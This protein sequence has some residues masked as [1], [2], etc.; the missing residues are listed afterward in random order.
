MP[1]RPLGHLR[2]LPRGSGGSHRRA[3]LEKAIPKEKLLRVAE[4]KPKKRKLSRRDLL[5]FSAL[6]EFFKNYSLAA[7]KRRGPF[8]APGEASIVQIPDACTMALA[9]D[10]GTGTDEAA[11][12][13]DHMKKSDPDYTIHLGDIYYVGSQESIDENCRGRKQR[14]GYESV[15]WPMGKHGSFALN[16]N[17][18]AYARDGAYFKWIQEDLKQPSSCFVLHNQNWCI[19]GLDTAY[20]SEG[21]PWIGW[22]ADY[23]GWRWFLPSCKIPDA[24]LKWLE[25]EVQPYLTLEKGLILL[26]HHQYFSSF[27]NEYR[28]AAQQLSRINGFAN[29]DLLWFWGHEH[30]LSAYDIY[31]NQGIRAFGRCLGHGGM[32]VERDAPKLTRQDRPLQFYDWRSY[33]PDT[34][35]IIQ[36]NAEKDQSTFGVNG[37][38]TFEFTGASLKV[39]CRDINNEEIASEV[40]GVNRGNV[41]V[42]IPTTFGP[43]VT[44]QD[45][46]LTSI[47]AAA[48]KRGQS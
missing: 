13:A 14:N 31:G 4:D 42:Q 33:D 40:W 46:K 29:R 7:I 36:S 9:G 18:E 20:N 10:W 8:P 6:G 38:A 25:T 11:R 28:N 17:H 41:V 30:R 27:D 34:R 5:D 24:A 19:I 21:I 45:K 32:P 26:S 48:S 43:M 35:R 16:G 22:L 23:F 15:R 3:A 2:D 39:S 47:G 37:Y 1:R 44:L 12:I